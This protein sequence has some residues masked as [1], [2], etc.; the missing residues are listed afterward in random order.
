MMVAIETG[1]CAVGVEW[2]RAGDWRVVAHA[3][4]DY[5]RQLRLGIGWSLL[6][7]GEPMP[8]AVERA[9]CG[10]LGIA[11]TDTGDQNMIVPAE[12]KLPERPT[13]PQQAFTL[14]CLSW[15]A[16]E[17][18]GDNPYPSGSTLWAKWREGWLAARDSAG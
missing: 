13:S 1:T 14:G 2:A 18:E 5:C 9:L 15:L 8:R 10:A 4:G 6:H 11:V 16:G 3:G 17:G 12:V 7:N